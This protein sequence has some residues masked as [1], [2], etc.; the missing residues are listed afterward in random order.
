MRSNTSF[1]NVGTAVTS[2]LSKTWNLWRRKIAKP[3]TDVLTISWLN[4][5]VL[6]ALRN[7]LSSTGLF[8]FGW[9]L[10]LPINRG[11]CVTSKTRNIPANIQWYVIR[12]GTE[13]KM[14][15]FLSDSMKLIEYIQS[16]PQILF[17]LIAHWR[18]L[19]RKSYKNPWEFIEK[20]YREPQ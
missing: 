18:I 19:E 20:T 13:D 1:G 16:F 4:N 9:I 5:T 7:F 14:I 12:T 3:T 8:V 15:S 6:M 2:I 10:Y 11:H 17:T